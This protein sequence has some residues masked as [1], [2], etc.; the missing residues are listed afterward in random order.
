MKSEMVPTFVGR[1]DGDIVIVVADPS[2][3]EQVLAFKAKH[4]LAEMVASVL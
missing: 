3:A 1:R 4:V 2:I